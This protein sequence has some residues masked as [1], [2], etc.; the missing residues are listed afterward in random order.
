M[1]ALKFRERPAV[2]YAGS[3]VSKLKAAFGLNLKA[4]RKQE[5][6]HDAAFERRN[7]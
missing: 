4:T 2:P 3:G 6:S 7:D 5:L 1:V